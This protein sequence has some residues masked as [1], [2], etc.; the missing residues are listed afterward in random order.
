M[1]DCHE[2]LQPAELE[3]VLEPLD[4]LGLY[5][6]ED[7]VPVHR[8]DLLRE[9]RRHA[10]SRLAGGERSFSPD[11]VRAAVQAG[12]VDV[13]MPDVKHAG[14]LAR[15][16]ALGTE[17]P[18]VG[19]SPHNPCGPIATGH[20]AH[21]FV[22]CPTATVLEYAFGEVEWRSALVYGAERIRGGYLR[23][24]EAPGLGLDLDLSHPNLSL[25]H[26]VN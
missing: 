13:L 17:F 24:P 26:C 23:L 5:W 9:L 11:E 20:S 8:V 18:S 21:L 22:T 19:I 25:L 10:R 1:V 3:Q 4:E 12:L 16:R 2:Q 15:A 7:A 6:L 14:G